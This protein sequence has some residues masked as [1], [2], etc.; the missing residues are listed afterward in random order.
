MA[1]RPSDKVFNILKNAKGPGD[2]YNA[3]T[4]DPMLAI[5]LVIIV[6]LI[7]LFLRIYI[8]PQI[9]PFKFKWFSELWDWLTT[10]PPPSPLNPTHLQKLSTLLTGKENEESNNHV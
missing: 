1:T 8:W 9:N 4:Q 3:L 2:V 7:L 10:R 5:G 6:G